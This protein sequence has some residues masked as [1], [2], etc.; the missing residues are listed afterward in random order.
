MDYCC[1]DDGFCF[2]G[3]V[4]DFFTGEA[5]MAYGNWSPDEEAIDDF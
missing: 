2:C 3:A 5:C 1:R 4:V